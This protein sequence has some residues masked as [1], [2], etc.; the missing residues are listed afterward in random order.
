MGENIDKILFEEQLNRLRGDEAIRKKRTRAVRWVKAQLALKLRREAPARFSLSKDQWLRFRR[1]EEPGFSAA[2]EKL[3]SDLKLPRVRL[4]QYRALEA[5]D[6]R[7][8]AKMLWR[9][10]LERELKDFGSRAGIPN[11]TWWRFIN[12]KTYSH[13]ETASKVISALGLG[14]AE[15]EKLK[16]LLLRGKFEDVEPL[17]RPAREHIKSRGLSITEFLRHSYISQDAW[18]PFQPNGSGTVSQGTLLK[19]A[20]GLSLTPDRAWSFLGLVQSGFFMECDLHVLTYMHISCA[21]MGGE[22]DYIPEELAE[23]LDEYSEAGNF[24]NPY[25]PEALCLDQKI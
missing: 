23:L 24:A 11:P 9:E 8:A 17:K 5:H 4:R 3:L 7:M 22:A 19:L 14:A 2:T 18:E 12:V 16:A 10:L 1:G 21:L 25:P 13:P 20:V 15:E 6:R